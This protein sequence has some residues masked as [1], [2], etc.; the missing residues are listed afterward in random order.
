MQVVGSTANVVRAAYA[1]AK[2]LDPTQAQALGSADAPAKPASAAVS[3]I[4]SSTRLS[5]AEKGAF[6]TLIG[7]IED[8]SGGARL[9]ASVM[10]IVQLTE[11]T[12]AEGSFPAT[13]I[14]AALDKKTARPAFKQRA[15]QAL[16]AAL[17]RLDVVA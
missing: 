8:T 17:E 5:T 9:I 14:A 11:S 16:L 1:G 7:D 6:I 4:M 12:R 3:Y 13:D 10:A 2:N 15:E